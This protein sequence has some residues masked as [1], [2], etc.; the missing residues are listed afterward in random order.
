MVSVSHKSGSHYKQDL[1]NFEHRPRLER[2][3]EVRYLRNLWLRRYPILPRHR[4]KNA[5]GFLT[6][7]NRLQGHLVLS[8]YGNLG[9][10][11]AVRKPHLPGRGIQN[12]PK[13]GELNAPKQVMLQKTNARKS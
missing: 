8:N 4:V 5:D 7:P 13:N 10:S 12:P 11:G 2:E 9:G 3:S 1:R 6:Q